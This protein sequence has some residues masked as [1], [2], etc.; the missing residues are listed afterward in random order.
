ML[1]TGPF[2]VK[3]AFQA[4]SVS[5]RKAGREPS[6]SVPVAWQAETAIVMV[7][8][9]ATT[10][11]DKATRRVVLLEFVIDA[12]PRHCR[13]NRRDSSTVELVAVERRH[14]GGLKRGRQILTGAAV[15]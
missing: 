10:I 1:V 13:W 9:Q 7:R 6:P 5:G 8:R 15:V 11:I 3:T 4:K 12:L 14:K 2:A